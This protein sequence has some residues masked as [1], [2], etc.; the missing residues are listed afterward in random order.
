M[1]KIW[2]ENVFVSVYSNAGKK[3]N[4]TSGELPKSLHGHGFLARD[5]L[6]VDWWFQSGHNKITRAEFP[7]PAELWMSATIRIQEL[8]GTIKQFNL[9]SELL[10]RLVWVV[11]RERANPPYSLSWS[12]GLAIFYQYAKSI[13]K[14]SGN[15]S[16]VDSK[17]KY[18]Q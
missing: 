15:F 1:A 11:K 13:P 14:S 16:H 2:K 4:E 8:V 5:G 9:Q 6:T 7:S 3:P 17:I 18:R 10:V 12:F